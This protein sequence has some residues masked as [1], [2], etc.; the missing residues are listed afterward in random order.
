[1]DG[2]QDEGNVKRISVGEA[3][4]QCTKELTKLSECMRHHPSRSPTSVVCE[5]FATSLGWC[6]TLSLCTRQARELQA[7]CGGIPELVSCERRRCVREHTQLDRC[8]QQF[9]EDPTD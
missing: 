2:N 9:T 6:I 8:M 3:F 1:M 4:P 7:C 5:R